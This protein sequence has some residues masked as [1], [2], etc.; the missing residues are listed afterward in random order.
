MTM[1]LDCLA[2]LFVQAIPKMSI[3]RLCDICDEVEEMASF[4]GEMGVEVE[5]SKMVDAVK[6]LKTKI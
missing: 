2:T 4:Q 6:L 5:C 1:L 3:Y